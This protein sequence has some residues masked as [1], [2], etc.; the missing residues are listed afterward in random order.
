MALQDNFNNNIKEHWSEITMTTIKIMQK[1]DILQE[2]PKG[3]TETQTEQM[4]LE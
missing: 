1:F 4:L 3:D 2:L